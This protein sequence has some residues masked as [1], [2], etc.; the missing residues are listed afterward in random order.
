MG[1]THHCIS[2][3]QKNAKALCDLRASI[4]L[5]PLDIFNKL[6]LGT[7]RP[8]TMKLL[9]ADRTVNKLVGIL[10]DVLVRVDRFIFSA[11]FVILDCEVYF[12]VPIILG[13]PFL[14]M[15]HDL[16]DVERG[17]LKFRMNDEEITFQI[18]KSMK[19][20]A[21]MSVVSVIYTIDEAIETT[22]EHEHASEMLAAVIMNY[23]GE[24]EEEF[25]ETINALVGMGTY[26]YNPKKLDL[27]LENREKPPAKPC[28]IEPPTLELKPLPSHL[29]Y[30]FLGPNNTFP[31]IIS[32]WLT[33]E[34]R[35]RLMVI[36]R[37]YK[38]AIGWC[39]VDIQ[40]IPPRISTHKI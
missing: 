21:D 3:V 9:M 39:I 17:D 35:H 36:L 6:G 28:I 4:N 1:V 15:G 25:E 14:A 33:D 34:Q 16:V 13:R 10:Y 20:P 32:V 22:V 19:Q 12:K 11:E 8:T 7:S 24:N 31:V 5:I 30:E 37:K 27:D 40:G 2:L 26:K 18:Y 29:R 23:E 38:K